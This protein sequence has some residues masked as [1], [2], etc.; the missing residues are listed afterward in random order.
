MIK[1]FRRIRQKLITDGKLSKYLVYALGEIALVMI[2]ILL[3]LQVNNWNE[4]RKSVNQENLALVDL[5]REF[6]QSITDLESMQETR[7]KQEHQFRDYYILL[8]DPN[9]PPQEKA[10]SPF[11]LTYDGVWAPTL[12]VLNGM[13]SSGSIDNIKN[14]S[15]KALLTLWPNSVKDYSHFENEFFNRLNELEAYTGERVPSAIVRQGDYDFSPSAWPGNYHPHDLKAQRDEAMA[16]LVND[17][18]FRNYMSDITKEIYIS[19]IVIRRLLELYDTIEMLI[20]E[21]LHK[22]NLEIPSLNINHGAYQY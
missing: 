4:E 22:R 12:D 13:I 15:L 2:G 18:R 8:T 10:T 9:I 5:Y 19:L 7:I 14:D 16:R 3:A 11:P 21:E 1:F 20:T 6:A 17:V